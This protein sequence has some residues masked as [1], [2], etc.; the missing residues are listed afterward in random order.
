VIF[1]CVQTSK[2]RAIEGLLSRQCNL[3]P[4]PHP[5]DQ[6]PSISR[7]KIYISIKIRLSCAIQRISPRLHY[8][9]P[10]STQPRP[11]RS[12]PMTKYLFLQ[13]IK[14]ASNI[15]NQT[16]CFVPSGKIQQNT[17]TPPPHTNRQ[18][19]PTKLVSSSAMRARLPL[20]L[21]PTKC[22]TAVDVPRGYPMS[23][24]MVI[25]GWE[26]S[27]VRLLFPEVD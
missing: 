15:H 27:Y 5:Q 19:A 25:G 12:I 22:A 9:W 24:Q 1:L 2:I 26:A 17:G 20:Q 6:V 11:R 10:P 21:S 8:F 4:I 7:I 18:R 13:S 14:P 3:S 16:Q 23:L